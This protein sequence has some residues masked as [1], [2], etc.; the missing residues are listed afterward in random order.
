MIFVI[1]VTG[2]L[3]ILWILWVFVFP[4][5]GYGSSGLGIFLLV[6][7][8]LALFACFFIVSDSNDLARDKLERAA[9]K[10]VAKAKAE[11]EKAEQEPEFFDTRD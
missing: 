10:R 2:S 9:E 4:K 6:V 5:F 1:P 3:A 11:A 8:F 7:F